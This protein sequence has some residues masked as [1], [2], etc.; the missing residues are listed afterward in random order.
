MGKLDLPKDK[1]QNGPVMDRSCTD[2]I[3][4]FLFLAFLVGMAGAGAYGYIN[5]DPA[6]LLV[7]WDYDS[8]DFELILKREWVRL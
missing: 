2:I 7:G 4:C 3:C 8:K 1:L 6:L 5:G